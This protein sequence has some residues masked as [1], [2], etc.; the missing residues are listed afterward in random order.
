VTTRQMDVNV[1]R[2]SSDLQDLGRGLVLLGLAQ[3]QPCHPSSLLV[4]GWDS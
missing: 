4:N 2:I 3:V 1:Q